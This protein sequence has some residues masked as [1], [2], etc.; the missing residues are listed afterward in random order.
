MS[1]ANKIVQSFNEEC[2]E[3]GYHAVIG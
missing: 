3:T 1:D 2:G